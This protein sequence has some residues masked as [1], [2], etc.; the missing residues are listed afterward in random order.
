VLWSSVVVAALLLLGVQNGALYG[1]LVP[2]GALAVAA[3]VPGALPATSHKV[4]RRDLLAVCGFY[5]AIVALFCLAFRVFTQQHVAGLFLCFAG[6]LLLGV[7][8]PL[9]YT[10]WYRGR[11]LADLGITRRNLRPALALGLL[12]AAIQFALTLWGYQLPAPVDWV[13]LAVLAVTVGLFEAIFF[14]GFVQTRLTAAFGPIPGVGGA[15]VLY[16]LYH[17]GYG[18]AGGEMLFLFGLGVLY[19]VAYA[20]VGNILV[21]WPLL[22]PFGSFFS[23]LSSGTIVM[24]WAAI[25]GFADV[26]ALMGAAV[27]LAVRRDRRQHVRGALVAG[28][29]EGPAAAGGPGPADHV[30]TR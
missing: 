28:E 22:I 1:V 6:G 18:M 16:A 12:F 10:V 4:D 13:P 11:P 15:A 14:R 17:V 20:T 29:Q 24:P 19:A 2:A 25:L 27:W 5:L 30:G 9:I 7:L 21:L 26:L 8:G 3:L 23:N